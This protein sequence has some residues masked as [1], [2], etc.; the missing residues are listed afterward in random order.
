MPLRQLTGQTAYGYACDKLPSNNQE[1]QSLAR[2]AVEATKAVHGLDFE[3]GPIC[4]TIYPATGSSVDYVADVV[5]S[6]Y[7][8]T[9]ELRDKGQSGFLLPE[10]Q[11]RPAGEESFAGFLH[12]LQNMK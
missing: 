6:D 8:F 11:I 4:S 12:L 10:N 2:G 1:Y 9:V 5:E 3:Y 7:T